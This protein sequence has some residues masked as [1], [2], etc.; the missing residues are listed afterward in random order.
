M[1]SYRTIKTY[2]KLE[3]KWKSKIL[4]GYKYHLIQIIRFLISMNDIMMNFLFLWI[5]YINSS[6]CEFDKFS[7]GTH[8]FSCNWFCFIIVENKWAEVL[9]MIN[10]LL[11]ILN[12]S[13]NFLIYLSFCGKQKKRRTKYT[14]TYL[15]TTTSVQQSAFSREQDSSRK[16]VSK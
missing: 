5:L 2:L 3:R 6:R 12:S 16:T 10:N 15:T 11:T 14:S 13:F 7:K 4:L 8:Y 9:V 1:S